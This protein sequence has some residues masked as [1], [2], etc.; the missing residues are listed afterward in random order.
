MKFKRN[1]WGY[2]MLEKTEMKGKPGKRM[3]NVANFTPLLRAGYT[4][5]SVDSSSQGL[6]S[7]YIFT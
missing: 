4:A 3:R 2:T 5:Y 7:H 1:R 6:K